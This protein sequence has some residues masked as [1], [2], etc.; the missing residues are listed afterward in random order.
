MA[1][2][3]S[4]KKT[5]LT[6]ETDSQA[7]SPDAGED[8]TSTPSAAEEKQTPNRN[9]DKN[10]GR[11]SGHDYTGCEDISVHHDTLN[12]G[13]ACPDCAK[14]KANGKLSAIDPGVVI[15]LDGHPL[16]TGKTVL[17]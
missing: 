12:V 15:K 10:H 1:S 7:N 4:E 2:P 9:P 16:I 5:G 8:T 13:D 17:A 6:A 14:G 11:Y 3:A